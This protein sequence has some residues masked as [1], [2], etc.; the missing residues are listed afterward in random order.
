MRVDDRETLDAAAGPS[1]R[2]LRRG[3]DPLVDVTEARPVAESRR[4]T[5][6]GVVAARQAERTAA[7]VSDGGPKT[8][9]KARGDESVAMDG[10]LTKTTSR[11][12]EGPT[13]GPRT[14]TRARDDDAAAT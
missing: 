12:D 3:D 1:K 4:R 9:T 13:A 8:E 2:T 10:P 11:D 6:L 7:F 5:L 14:E